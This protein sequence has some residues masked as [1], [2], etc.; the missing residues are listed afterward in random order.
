MPSWPPK[1]P[2]AVL[3]YLYTIPL[4]EGDSVTASTFTQLS[5]T[6]DIESQSRTAAEWTIELSGGEDG[7]TSVF[8]VEWTTAAGREDDDIITIAVIENAVLALTGYAK[9]TPTHLVTRYPAFAAVPPQTILYWLTDAE[10]YV[11]HGWTEG[12]YAAALMALAAHNMSLA[13]LEVAAVAVGPLP[14]GVTRIKSGSFELGFTDEAA[15]AKAEGNLDSTR[16]GAEF[17]SLLRRNRAG[18]R[19]MPTGAIPYPVSWQQ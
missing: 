10:R 19:V 13:G 18:P 16:Y 12:D 6:V 9:P 4:D 8:R 2:D 15:N 7:E 1:D 14:A 17:K 3:D 5:G 11:D